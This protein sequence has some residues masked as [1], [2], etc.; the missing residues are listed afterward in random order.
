MAVLLQAAERKGETMPGIIRM[1]PVISSNVR[2]VGYDRETQRL[3]VEFKGG[4]TYIYSGVRPEKWKALLETS[5][6]KY[7]HKEIIGKYPSEKVE[8]KEAR[9]LEIEGGETR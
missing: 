5:I 7:L 8:A 9:V 2:E 6:G 1:I 4:R 3:A